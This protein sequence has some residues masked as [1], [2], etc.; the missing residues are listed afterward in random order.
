MTY[1]L[2]Q[3]FLNAIDSLKEYGIKVNP[4]GISRLYD[5]LKLYQQDRN[6]PEYPLYLVLRELGS[7]TYLPIDK[8]DEQLSDDISTIVFENYFAE[9][10]DQTI[11][12]ILRE[13]QRISKGN[14][15]SAVLNETVYDE[16]GDQTSVTIQFTLLDKNL[17]LT[18]EDEY[19]D[20]SLLEGFL[21]EKLLPALKGSITSGHIL[22]TCEFSINLIYFETASDRDKFK[23]DFN[24]YQ[25][26]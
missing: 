6:N 1:Q 22:Y 4:N 24:Y 20:G 17:E 8:V 25:E 16:D 19:G 18:H 21:S 14:F 13:I 3:K 26:I 7:K 15:T 23:L 10:K 9:S 5:N 11:S 2:D 12:Y